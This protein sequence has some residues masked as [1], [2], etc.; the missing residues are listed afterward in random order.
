[1]EPENVVV[2]KQQ[3]STCKS[4]VHQDLATLAATRTLVGTS[5]L[6]RSVAGSSPIQTPRRSTVAVTRS[7]VYHLNQDQDPCHSHWD[8]NYSCH[9]PRNNNHG[10]HDDDYDGE[11]TLLPRKDDVEEGSSRGRK[12][13]LAEYFQKRGSHTGDSEADEP[14]RA[15]RRPSASYAASDAERRGQGSSSYRG[16]R[17]D[18]DYDDQ[19]SYS[20]SYSRGGGRSGEGGGGSVGGQ[21]HSEVDV[22][23]EDDGFPRDAVSNSPSRR[24]GSAR[25]VAPESDPPPRNRSSSLAKRRQSTAAG[26]KLGGNGLEDFS[27][28]ANSLQDDRRR[29]LATPPPSPPPF[30][31]NRGK[32]GFG[33]SLLPASVYNIHDDNESVSTT[34]N[35]DTTVQVMDHWL[36]GGM[37][38]GTLTPFQVADWLRTLPVSKFER[39]AKKTLA[40]RVLHYGVDGEEFYELLTSGKWAELD[41]R[42]EREAVTL[43]RLFKQRQHEGAMAQ[44]ARNT[45]IRNAAFKRKG[46]KV[47][48]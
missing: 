13:T 28:E 37:D 33:A 18:G 19:E 38:E 39:E 20:H 9:R 44:A 26:L 11:A 45:A 30:P 34:R 43:L 27:M 16:G 29:S 41:L 1:M 2:T 10:F 12:G 3:S 17:D 14:G 7:P 24:G 8:E 21:R 4:L 47:V 31:D 23:M 46:A 35:K 40:R 22:N 5:Q 25:G 32:P 48:A 36:D 42:D 15:L 6:E